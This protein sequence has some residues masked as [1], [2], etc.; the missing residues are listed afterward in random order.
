[1]H[2]K[3]PS[4]LFYINI[5]ASTQHLEEVEESPC[6]DDSVV[7]GDHGWHC[8]HSVSQTLQAWG[9]PTKHL[10]LLS[11]SSKFLLQRQ[12]ELST[13][14]K[15]ITQPLVAWFCLRWTTSCT[16]QV[17]KPNF[18]LWPMREHVAWALRLQTLSYMFSHWSRPNPTSSQGG[19]VIDSHLHKMLLITPVVLTTSSSFSPGDL[20][21]VIPSLGFLTI[22][23]FWIFPDMSGFHLNS[24]TLHWK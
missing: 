22:C 23:K 21:Q 15:A 11:Q 3:S 13:Q 18:G 4:R 6:H 14:Y 24:T 5:F 17:A 8:Q 2:H 9:K 12:Q 19:W 20:G 1:M 7:E 10:D 16:A